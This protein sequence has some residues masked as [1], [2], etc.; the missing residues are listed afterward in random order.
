MLF[1]VRFEDDPTKLLVRQTLLTAHINYLDSVKSIVLLAGSLRD[2]LLG[3]PVGGL[4][5]VEACNKAAVM[6]IIQSDPFWKGGLRKSWVI[7]HW[8]RAFE[9]RQVLI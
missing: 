7:Q 6:E 5:I 4:W 1:I 9:D 2:D 8:S 3:F